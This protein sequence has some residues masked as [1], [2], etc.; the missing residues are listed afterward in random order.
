MG[1]SG[2]SYFEDYVE[3]VQVAFERT[4]RRVLES[5][6]Y[7]KPPTNAVNPEMLDGQEAYMAEMLRELEEA[8]LYAD[9]PEVRAAIEKER[10]SMRLALGLEDEGAE[11]LEDWQKEI[12]TL[13][14]RAQTEGTHSILDIERVNT[15]TRP[16]KKVPGRVYDPSI[17]YQLSYGASGQSST[18]YA[19]GALRLL[20]DEELED[21][22]GTTHP[23]R[24]ATEES[25]AAFN[26]PRWT[27]IAHA[28]Y[29]DSGAPTHWYFAGF[30][31]D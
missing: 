31:G 18:G 22:Y 15:D 10:T 9:N 1:A 27:G 20:T 13:R 30:S 3:D 11:G 7:T 6:E 14:A 17:V 8:L 12:V 4:Q 21:I 28:V 23:T 5:G 24:E 16:P 29:D 2:W 19:H 25:D 26:A